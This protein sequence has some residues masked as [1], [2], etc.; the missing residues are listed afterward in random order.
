MYVRVPKNIQEAELERVVGD[1]K[2]K[3]G[4]RVLKDHL[5]RHDDLR[6]RAA[7]LNKKYFSGAL[8]LKAIEYV[9]GQK[10]KFG[11]CDFNNGVIRIAH[12]VAAMP[13]WVREYVLMHELAHLVEP[14]HGK[15]FWDIVARYPMAERAKGFLLAKGYELNET[16]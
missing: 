16:E 2:E 11:C 7:K 3:L 9:T 1:F 13:V 10:T 4:S 6:Q 14:N 5:N 8:K 12:H 15:N